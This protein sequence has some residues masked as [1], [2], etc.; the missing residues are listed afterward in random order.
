MVVRQLLTG[1]FVGGV[2]LWIF[3]SAI[4]GML[5]GDITTVAGGGG[6]AAGTPDLVS[7]SRAEQPEYF[8]VAVV[9]HTAVGL[10]GMWFG[11][12]CLTGREE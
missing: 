5:T 8:W 2:G 11:W 4:V 7:T 1:V 3:G 9:A 6:R 12:R 10:F